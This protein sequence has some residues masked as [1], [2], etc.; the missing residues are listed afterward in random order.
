MTHANDVQWPEIARDLVPMLAEHAVRHDREGSFVAECY[1]ALR[2]RR[3]MSAFVPTEL[4]GGG[5]SLRELCELLRELARGC[6]STSLALSMHQ[7]LV[8]VAVWNFR[9]GKPTEKL[10]RRVASEQI[11]LV[12]TGATDW[13]DSVGVMT[14]VSGGYTV[15]A[16]KVFG[17]G[18][19]AAT[20]VMTSARYDDPE[21]GPRVLHFA[22]PLSAKGVTPL[23]DWDTLG[24]RGTGSQSLKLEGVFVPDEAITL[25]RPRGQWPAILS[26][27]ATV[28][29]P[30]VMSP[31][32]GL[33]A[34]ACREALSHAAPKGSDPHVAARAGR[35]RNALTAAELAWN[36]MLENAAEL[37]F[38]PDLERANRALICK[39]LC[40]NAVQEA[41]GHALHLA[42]GRGFYRKLSLE[43][44]FRDVQAAHFHPLPEERQLEFT[45]RLAV[46]RDP[47]TGE[48][49]A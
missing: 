4:G 35:M 31:Y 8:A 19:P 9:H 20:L 11:V 2:E 32:V 24:M 25:S 41:V 18:S 38:E 34:E 33:A 40:A 47:V 44:H 15:D 27:V 30:I 5:A 45:G 7:H 6:A 1:A 37:A 36:A 23:D 13:V 21:L 48:P 16:V 10:L 42:G 39:T 49:R 46:G 29:L 3:V 22:V 14:K 28:A 26:V 43:R 17:S 12:S